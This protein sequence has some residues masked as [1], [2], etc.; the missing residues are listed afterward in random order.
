MSVVKEPGQLDAGVVSD[1]EELA[2]MEEGAHWGRED[3]VGGGEE[4]DAEPQ[5]AGGGA[6]GCGFGEDEVRPST[7]VGASCWVT[8]PSASP[9]SWRK[10]KKEVAVKATI[11][12][13]GD[14]GSIHRRWGIPAFQE[15]SGDGR[16]EM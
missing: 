15:L 11:G 16:S 2:L 7:S 5:N 14:Q 3:V 9:V 6:P 4:A 8:C 10:R 13:A 1:V 12:E